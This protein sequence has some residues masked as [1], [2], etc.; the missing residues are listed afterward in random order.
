MNKTKPLW[1]PSKERIKSSN[2]SKYYEF[3]RKEYNLSFSNYSELHSWSVADIETFWESIW[4]FSGI[5]YSKS[6]NKIIDKHIMPGAKW[7]EG[8]SLNFAENLL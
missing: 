6:Y 3:L 1:E 4:K 8:A 7:F 5:I 2:F